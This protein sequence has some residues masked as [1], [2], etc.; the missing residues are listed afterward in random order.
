MKLLL[1]TAIQS[2]EPDI[3]EMLHE[4]AVKKYS[5]KEV[6]GYSDSN[7]ESIV[8]NWFASEGNE[9]NSVLFYAFVTKETAAQVF[10]LANAFNDQQE[11]HSLVH[12]V[13]LNIEKSNHPQL[14]IV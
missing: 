8:D 10:E 3:R 2:F 7:H 6:K 9:T 13:V 1:I 14:R 12:V 11:S 5:F 4:A